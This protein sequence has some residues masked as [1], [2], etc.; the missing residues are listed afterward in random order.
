MTRA[1]PVTSLMVLMLGCG[2]GRA[3]DT[4]SSEAE[5]G[6]EGEPPPYHES[7]EEQLRPLC[8]AACEDHQQ[9]PSPCSACDYDTVATCTVGCLGRVENTDIPCGTCLIEQLSWDPPTCGMHY[10]ELQCDGGRAW[11]PYP[12]AEGACADACAQVLED[13]ENEAQTPEPIGFLPWLE[14]NDPTIWEHSQI[15]ADDDGNVGLITTSNFGIHRISHAGQPTWAVAHDDNNDDV[16]SLGLAWIDAGPVVLWRGASADTPVLVAYDHDGQT[17]WSSVLSVDASMQYVEL[18]ST[19]VD[20]VLVVAG[21]ELLLVDPDGVELGA[22]A[23]PW[24]GVNVT[25]IASDGQAGFVGL[26]DFD[27]TS[28]GHQQLDV[29]TLAVIGGVIELT[30]QSV[31]EVGVDPNDLD[32]QQLSLQHVALSPDGSIA[33]GGSQRSEASLTSGGSLS[34]NAPWVAAYEPD[35]TRR[36][37]WRPPGPRVVGGR[38]EAITISPDGQRVLAAAT[39]DPSHDDV[40]VAGPLC[41]PSDCN[42]IAVHVFDATGLLWSYE[43]R[44]VA[45]FAKAATWAHDGDAVVVGGGTDGGILL[46]FAPGD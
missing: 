40:G 4:A 17:R 8:E 6:A 28:D 27:D 33:V 24:L 18:V 32:E 30:P 25:A 15:A 38:I 16:V 5:S 41:S 31:I 46:R 20:G 43:H 26:L 13:W 34:Y 14:L 35:G 39:E 2:P 29:H 19:H 23:M 36:L 22:G 11:F 42:G 37:T 3:S 7:L 10:D 45:S 9:G 1:F 12:D 21:D 44:Q